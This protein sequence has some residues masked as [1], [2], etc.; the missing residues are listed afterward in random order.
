MKK[1]WLG[2]FSAL[3][4]LALFAT[5]VAARQQRFDGLQPGAFVTFKQTVPINLVLIG[6]D[7]RAVD[8]DDL[9]KELPKG[10][11]PLVRNAQLYGL[12]G[13]NLGL[14]YDFRY[15]VRDASSRFEDQ[16]F[17]Y[18]K[19][20]GKAG[21]LTSFQQQYNDQQK[22]VLDVTGPVLY[23]DAPA[24]EQWLTAHN[25]D[26]G[27]DNQR[28]YT[29][30]FI[31][32]YSRKDFKFHVYTKTS[33]PDPDTGYNFGEQ[34]PSRKMIAWGGS[35]SRSWFYDLSAG[36]EAWTSNFDVDNADI[37]GNGV[38]DYR[39]PPIWEY[40]SKGFRKPSKLSGDLGKV[41]R[42][43]GIDLLFTTSPLY[44]PLV[45]APGVGG[46]KIA[47]INVLEDDPTS[48]GTD[49]LDS[50]LALDKWKEFE[51][52]YGWR[53]RVKDRKPIDANAQKA[54]HIFGGSLVQDDCWNAYEDTFAELFCYFD[55]NRSKYI[56][57]SAERNYV[58][59]IFAFNTTDEALSG[60]NLL[61]FADDNWADGTQSYVFEFDTAG[62]REFGYGFTTTTIHEFGHHIGMSHPHD[63]YD[64][65]L[66]LDFDGADAYLFAQS[67]DES[68][69]IMSY[70]DLSTGFSQF[71]RDNMYRWETA[72]YINWSNE[73]LASILASPNASKVSGL[74]EDADQHAKQAR[75]SF[76]GW[77]YLDAVTHARQAYEDIANAAAKLGIAPPARVLARAAAPMSTPKR[78]PQPIPY[79]TE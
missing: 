15:R 5:P 59:G 28:G 17:G 45:T 38:D 11:D 12:P 6:Y 62:D 34:R 25:N 54:L 26:L 77:E 47:Y 30:Y 50:K 27:I 4:L 76:N 13:R 7:R 74:L 71:D 21:P 36:P 32:W 24:T 49:W 55:A 73:L 35:S 42:F 18:L 2:L 51:P 67:G 33:E 65:E 29:I 46:D 40:S 43:V 19:D 16:F 78:P 44:D 31:N 14:H 53:V 72:G 60:T 79:P 52:Y 70:I 22:N 69:T 37:D 75:D 8:R 9:L 41:A 56:P 48:R 10:Y 3:M 23:V 63:G 68:A 61:G 57:H 64:S 20:I 66:H 58:G 1:G 39:M